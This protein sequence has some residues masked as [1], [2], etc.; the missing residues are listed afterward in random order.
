[1]KHWQ[2]QQNVLYGVKTWLDLNDQKSDFKIMTSPSDA[3]RQCLSRRKM[4]RNVISV[5]FPV[6]VYKT[7]IANCCCSPVR[8]DEKSLTESLI[9][10]VNRTPVLYSVLPRHKSCYSI[11]VRNM[12]QCHALAESS[13]VCA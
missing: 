10:Y 4:I 13:Q 6:F 12:M 9:Q 2:T 1:M 5:I 7:V 3:Q 11:L 8:F